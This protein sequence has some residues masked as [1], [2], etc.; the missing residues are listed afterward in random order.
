MKPTQ[1]NSNHQR[2]RI[3]LLGLTL[4]IVGLA[5]M[6][7]VKP[8]YEHLINTDFD[9]QG[10]PNQMLMVEAFLME[11]LAFVIG[12]PLAIIGAVLF[13]KWAIKNTV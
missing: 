9:Q 8:L 6:L 10:A 13:M 12:A 5:L 2:K 7:F 4:M 3:P 11:P 1:S